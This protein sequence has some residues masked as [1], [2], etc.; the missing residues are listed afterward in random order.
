MKIPFDISQSLLDR[1]ND[2]FP[3]KLPSKVVS[4]TDLAYLMGQRSVV[5]KLT[6]LYN[7][8]TNPNVYSEPS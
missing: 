2:L 6:D 4:S 1:L 8:E 7:E 3:D 5:D